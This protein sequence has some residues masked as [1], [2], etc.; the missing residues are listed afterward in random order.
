MYLLCVYVPE[1]HLE[2]LKT[3]IFNA[4]GGSIGDYDNCS[5]QVRGQ[6][7]FRPLA[8]SNPFIGHWG[9]VQVVDEYRVEVVIIK[10]NIGK[11]VEAMRAAHPYE[12]P[13]YY[14]VQVNTL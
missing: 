5:W 1:S 3:A 10:E 2:S 14:F 8:G 7:Q 12:E 9:Q 13:A 4:G 11:V 6:G